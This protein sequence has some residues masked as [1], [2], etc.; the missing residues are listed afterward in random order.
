MDILHVATALT[1]DAMDFLTFDRS[2]ARLAQAA[3]L[4]VKP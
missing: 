3:G 4:T 2:Q 1:V